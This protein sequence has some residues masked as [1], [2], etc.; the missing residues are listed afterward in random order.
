MAKIPTGN[1]GMRIDEPGLTPVGA[2]DTQ[3][4]AATQ[5]LGNTGLALANHEIDRM[6][7]EQKQLEARQQRVQAITADTKVQTGLAD[8]FD[9]IDADVRTGKID[10]LGALAA[11][12]DQSKQVVDDN[13][14]GLHADVSPAVRAQ[15]DGLAGKLTNRLFDTFRGQERSET[16]ATISSTSEQLQ[17]LATT[18]PEGALNRHAA[19]IDQLG[20]S[21]G[22]DSA[23]QAKAKQAFRE[24]VAATGVGGMAAAAYQQ[25]DAEKLASINARLA[26]PEGD[27]LDPNKKTQL[28]NQI[29]GW[30]Q[31]IRARQEAAADKAERQGLK[32]YNEGVTVLGKYQDVVA[33]GALLSAGAI[34]EIT[35]ATTG[36]GLE[37]QVQKLLAGQMEGA[38]FANQPVQQRQATIDRL[39][40]K[41]SDPAQ[42]VDAED[43]RQLNR[44]EQMD[45]SLR[46]RVDDGDAWAAYGDAGGQS[47]PTVKL[48]SPQ[49]AVEIFTQRMK[50]IGDVETWAGKKV[51]PL[52][53]SEA[54][55]FGKMLRALQPD[56]AASMLGQIGSVVGNADRVS[57]ISTQIGDKDKVMGMAMLFANAKTSMGRNTSEL[58]LRGDQAI[59]DKVVKPDGMVETGW[60]ASIS[61][62]V[63]G[64]YANQEVETN[65]IDAAFRIAAATD[66]DVDR[67]VRLATGGIVERNGQKIPL[68]YGID[69]KRFEKAI[70]I[71]T[72][73]NFADQAPGGRVVVGGVTLPLA[74]FVKTLPDARLVHAGQGVYNVRAGNTL[75]TNERGQRINVKV[76]P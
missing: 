21:A 7:F 52:Q 40:A 2:A 70:E 67:A 76:Q 60:R 61:K 23:Q 17:R 46:K 75:V 59:R 68:P 31:S 29:F 12:K 56:Q 14:Q 49:K 6:V 24:G 10:R 44:F 33:G 11:W 22:L 35:T 47:F 53:P 25:G 38:R 19:L 4:A 64:A 3:V 66:G 58:I 51:S 26:G 16:A 15:A 27:M 13:L 54:E 73:A 48:D 65:L 69:E 30:E 32:Q 50:D 39:R 57:A 5:R 37:P 42:G 8:T 20:G 62:Q 72:P 43:I 63:R 1:F 36:T 71:M 55:A 18:D 45:S 41:R 9:A 28:S 74:D 34:Q